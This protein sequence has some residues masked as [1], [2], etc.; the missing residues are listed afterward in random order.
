MRIGI[1]IGGSHIATG[2]VNEEGKIIDKEEKDIYLGE[3]AETEE[4][5]KE[6]IIATITSEIDN[7]LKKNNYTKSDISK[8]G[9]ATPGNPS[10]TNLRN[11]VNMKIK[12]FNIVDELKRSFNT[13][14]KVKNDGKCSGLAEK[15][16]G[17]LR[18]YED[19]IYLCLGT[20]VGSAVF[21]N[22][23]LLTPKLNTGFELGHMVIDKNGEQCNCGNR[24]CFETFAS[25][26][27]FRAK[28]I[29]AFNLP[30]DCIAEEVQ[31]YIRK[32]IERED[33]KAFIDE[34]IANVAIGVANLI[35]IFE[36]EAIA[37][38]GSFA[39]YDDIFMPS[40]K[41]QIEKH[42]F[43]KQTKYKLLVG[44]LKNDAGIIG[45]AEL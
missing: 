11:L 38:G 6:I 25:I 16:Y 14:I 18:G 36:P 29:K 33:V 2:I 3:V 1:D 32:N 19:C 34:Y 23:K 44:Q 4:R 17:V 7:L 45:A 42:L 31:Q 26:K 30:D 43:N 39:Y 28:F 21:L 9:I 12:D 27:R 41:K 40:L 5:A 8:I 37:F 35:N 13:T 24:G 22:N 20:G 15:K 10:A